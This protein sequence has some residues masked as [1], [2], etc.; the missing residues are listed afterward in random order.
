MDLGWEGIGAI[1]N[2]YMG[3][4]SDAA[5]DGA[6]A[7]QWY[8]ESCHPH[9]SDDVLVWGTEKVYNT[10]TSTTHASD[11]FQAVLIASS[12]NNHW[13]DESIA[14]I[15]GSPTA[16]DD[17]YGTNPISDI[18]MGGI[19][20]KEGQDTLA[21]AKF[22]YDLPTETLTALGQVI[23]GVTTAVRGG[24]RTFSKPPYKA[25]LALD[26]QGLLLAGH[27]KL[28]TGQSPAEV[29][30]EVIPHELQIGSLR[31]NCGGSHTLGSNPSTV[32]SR[33]FSNNVGDV[34]A[35]YSITVEATEA[36]FYGTNHWQTRVFS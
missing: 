18:T 21:S 24:N 34:G 12:P 30:E 33:S 14:G 5:V 36:S 25:S 19:R 32:A 35:T 17:T 10:T 26:G 9:T 16:G 6:N 20:H 2:L 29:E 13:Q 28:D 23:V 1:D 31:A 7:G 8:I 22:S 3:S 15:V 4:A 27:Y 11:A